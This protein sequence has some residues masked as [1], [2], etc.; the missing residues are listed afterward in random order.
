M[1]KHKKFKLIVFS[2][3]QIVGLIT[4]TVSS[5]AE[6]FGQ[7][8][9][10][11]IKSATKFSSVYTDSAKQ[12]K[13]AEP[14]FTCKGYGGYKLVLDIGGVFQTARIDALKSDFSMQIAGFQSIGWNPQVEW[15]MADGKPFAVIVRVD[16]NDENADIPK[17]LGEQLII[18]GLKGFENISET[19]DAKTAQANEKARE[20]ADR[21][22]SGD[23]AVKKSDAKISADT[24]SSIPI[25]SGDPYDDGKSAMLSD[26]QIKK[27]GALNAAVAVPTYVPASYKIKN[28]EI[29]EPEAHIVAFSIIYEDA[30]GKSFTIQ[31]NNEALGDMAVKREVR[32]S[33]DLFLPLGSKVKTSAF[34]AGHDE[35]D[36]TVVASE[37]LCSIGIYQPKKSKHSQCF[38][39]LS[40]DKS[41]SPNEAVKIMQSLRYLKR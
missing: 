10:G 11:K 5:G 30:A 1:S 27:L 31:S 33:S 26:A 7:S 15:R 4:L 21:G 34:Y 23:N 39:L 28:V 35:N 40:D 29:Q 13:G 36:V 38:Q 37:W 12:C 3:L 22:F 19:V 9:G 17:K 20:I 8:A 2:F 16:V 25:F 24:V 32:G 41:V 18:R 14:V 6:I